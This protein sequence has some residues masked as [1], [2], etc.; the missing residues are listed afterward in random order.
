MRQAQLRSQ[1]VHH[2]ASRLDRL[3]REAECFPV[4]F[5]HDRCVRAAFASL[6]ARRAAGQVDRVL[7]QERREGREKSAR[8]K[9][10]SGPVRG[11]ALD[12]VLPA[13]DRAINDRGRLTVVEFEREPLRRG[14]LLPIEAVRHQDHIPVVQVGQLGRCPLHVLARRFLVAAN[15]VR[16]D[17]SLIPIDM[18]HDVIE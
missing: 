5:F 14:D 11:P 7:R 2:R 15:P 4:T 6:F 3:S 18:Q 9:A 12:A 10:V 16:I 17:R 1:S 8:A 13:F